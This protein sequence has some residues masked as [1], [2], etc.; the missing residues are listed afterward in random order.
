MRRAVVDVGSN[1]VLL[2][3]SELDSNYVWNPILETSTVTGLGKLVRET[4]NIQENSAEKTLKAIKSAF[5][6]ATELEAPCKAAGTMALRL[7]KNAESFQELADKQQTPVQILS[8]EDEAR[9]GLEAVINDPIFEKYQTLSVIDP[10]GYSTELTVAQRN[11]N[12]DWSV[13]FQKSFEVGA[14]WLT[15]GVFKNESP[16]FAAR[17][18]ATED[19]DNVIGLDFLPGK[20]GQA[21]VLGATGTNLVSIRE[22]WAKWQ[23]DKVHGAILDYEEVGRAVGWLCDLTLEE[24]KNVIGLEKGREST[25]HSGAL[26]LERFLNSLHALDC[27]VSIR[28][29]RHAYLEKAW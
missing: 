10:G 23:P 8:G 2:L 26:I 19:I 25:I 24:R 20:S 14:L 17:L 9:L 16:D 28:G 1:S 7:A 27:V 5:Q 6:K 12:Q 22:K 13:L 11:N 4:G 18:Q 3:V 15:D 21:V 29:W